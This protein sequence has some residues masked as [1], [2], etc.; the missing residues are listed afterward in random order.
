MKAILWVVIV[1]QGLEIIGYLLHLM[2]GKTR[3]ITAPQLVGNIVIGFAMIVW[4]AVLLW[5]GV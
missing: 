2:C 1:S 3:V 5:G 4:A